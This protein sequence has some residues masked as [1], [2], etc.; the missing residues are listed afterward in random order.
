MGR[1]A[2]DILAIKDIINSFS[3]TNLKIEE[4]F[5]IINKNSHILIEQNFNVEEII[6]DFQ[7]IK[8]KKTKRK[9][10]N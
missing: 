4:I 10:L 8:T 7:N 6:N 2:T 5:T 1:L 3:N 9:G